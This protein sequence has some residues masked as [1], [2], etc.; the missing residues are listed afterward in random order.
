MRG[1]A[2]DVVAVASFAV[3]HD[4]LRGGFS[5]LDQAPEQADLLIIFA[6]EHVPELMRDAK[7][8]QGTH[9]IDE[10]R[11]RPVKGINVAAALGGSGPARSLG[12]G[13]GL[14]G[15]IVEMHF[16]GIVGDALFAHQ[17]A[18]VAI[19]REIMEAVIMHA[20]MGDVRG[21]IGDR[22]FAPKFQQGTIPGAVKS[23]NRAAILET[24]GPF[25]PTAAGIAAIDG[26]HR[27]TLARIPAAFDQLGFI[28]TQGEDLVGSCAQVGRAE[29]SINFYSGRAVGRAC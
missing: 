7:N 28:G 2:T 23:Q 9:S 5:V 18:Q 14:D 22:V 24:L 16:P 15:E 19:G 20:D 4:I 21:H 11:M 25:G 26:E 1:A 3:P 27:R 29:G 8:A 12:A 13:A 6:L 10:Q 17:A